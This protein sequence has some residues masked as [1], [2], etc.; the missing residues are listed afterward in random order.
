MKIQVDAERDQ[1][2]KTSQSTGSK[3]IPITERGYSLCQIALGHRDA[4]L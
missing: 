1:S 2:R 3:V 4:Y